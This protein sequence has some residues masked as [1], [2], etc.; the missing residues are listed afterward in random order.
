MEGP[1]C[2][3]CKPSTFYLEEAN[4]KGCTKCFCFGTTNICTVGSLRKDEVRLD[5]RS[6]YQCEHSIPFSLCELS[7]CSVDVGMLNNL[8]SDGV[9]VTTPFCRSGD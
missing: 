9:V 4:P 1:Q 7:Y 8:L 6:V 2:A 3:Q 5:S